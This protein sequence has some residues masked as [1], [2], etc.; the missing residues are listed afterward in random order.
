MREEDRMAEKKVRNWP[1][2]AATTRDV[3]PSTLTASL[4]A[5]A[6]TRT[7]TA[8]CGG[9]EEMEEG[10]KAVTTWR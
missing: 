4:F 2:M 5:P 7:L 8:L 10:E 1:L 9:V 6:S 3:R